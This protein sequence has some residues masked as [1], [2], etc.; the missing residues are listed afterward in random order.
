MEGLTRI[1]DKKSPITVKSPEKSV[2]NSGSLQIG[3][4]EPT[5][6]AMCSRHFL[7]ESG[8]PSQILRAGSRVRS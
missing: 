6:D 3:P 2:P 4:I 7:A 5:A 1:L 8:E